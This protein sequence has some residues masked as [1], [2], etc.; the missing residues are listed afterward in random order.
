M[1]NDVFNGSQTSQK[2]LTMFRQ[3][4]RPNTGF[5]SSLPHGMKNHHYVLE[6]LTPLFSPIYHGIRAVWVASI[7]INICGQ[8]RSNFPNAPSHLTPY[9]LIGR[10]EQMVTNCSNFFVIF[11]ISCRWSVCYKLSPKFG[12]ELFFYP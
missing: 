1:V 2:K 6:L 11:G 12:F 7:Y 9:L 3:H 4:V 5:S 8:Y 10:P